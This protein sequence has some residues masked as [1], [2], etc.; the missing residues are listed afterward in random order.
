MFKV[1]LGQRQ[2]LNIGLF[3]S[4]FS[5]TTLRNRMQLSVLRKR[6]SGDAWAEEDRLEKPLR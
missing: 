2:T 6:L 5:S 1:I 3:G 4:G